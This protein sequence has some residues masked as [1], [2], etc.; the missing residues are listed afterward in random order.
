MNERERLL[1]VLGGG[2]VDVIPWYADLSWWYDA[3]KIKGTLPEIYLDQAEIA[4][5]YQS[6]FQLTPTDG[7]GYLRLHQDTGVGI[8]AYAP[9]V[10]T[11]TFNDN[12]Q[13][14]SSL[15]H[16]QFLVGLERALEFFPFPF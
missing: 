5:S 1:T 4:P 6:H 8:F 10:W 14:G 7:V 12:I 2:K 16:Q 15:G 13:F 3:Q 11:E 9:M